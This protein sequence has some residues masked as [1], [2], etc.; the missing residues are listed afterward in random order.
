MTGY[1]GICDEH[2]ELHEQTCYV[3]TG[4]TIK[5]PVA[6]CIECPHCNMQDFVGIP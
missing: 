3:V 2:F 1:C 5:E 4:D 6:I